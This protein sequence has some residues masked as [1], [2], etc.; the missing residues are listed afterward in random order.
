MFCTIL[1]RTDEMTPQDNS[2]WVPHQ[3]QR[4]TVAVANQAKHV[5]VAQMYVVQEKQQQQTSRAGR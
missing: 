1:I 4:Q 3:K 2:F 5:Q